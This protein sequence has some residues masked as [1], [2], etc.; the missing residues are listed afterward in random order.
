[1]HDGAMYNEDASIFTSFMV[2]TLEEGRRR[3]GA[4]T[5]RKVCLLMDRSKVVMPGGVVKKEVLDMGVVPKLVELFTLLY[6]TLYHNYPDL[7][8]GAQVLPSSWF[9]SLCYRVTSQ[10]MDRD[11]RSKFEMISVGD[12]KKVMRAQFP[13]SAL[14]EHLGGSSRRYGDDIKFS[15][16]GGPD[17]YSW[18]GELAALQLDQEASPS[19]GDNRTALRDLGHNH[20]HDHD[21]DHCQGGLSSSECSSGQGS[22]LADHAPLSWSLEE[23]YVL[24]VQGAAWAG[25][26]GDSHDRGA[27][28]SQKDQSDSRRQALFFGLTSE[29][30]LESWI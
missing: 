8:A 24:G 11:T 23:Q 14:P 16:K 5:E 25:R 2:Y 15:V 20:N 27:R 1:M 4:G 7:L 19:G 26:L 21:H 17:P 3:Y 12:V 13:L 9:F 29:S 10:V 6:S 18:Q 30:L 28:S 22:D